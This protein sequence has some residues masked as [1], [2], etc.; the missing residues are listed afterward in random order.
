MKTH[1]PPLPLGY[2]ALA[3]GKVANVVTCLEMNERP[4]LR[5]VPELSQGIDLLPLARPDVDAY[6]ALFR[7]VGCD[8]LWSSR[9]VMPDE[10]L[11][12]ILENPQVE[13]YTLRQ[14][15]KPVGLLEL[16]F[17]E[18]GECELAFFGLVK[19]AIGTGAGRYLMDQAVAKAW[20]KPIRRFWVHTCTFDHQ[21]ALG[22]Y[23]RSGFRPYAFA[24]E[25]MDDPRLTGHL[26]RAAAPHIALLE[27]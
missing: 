9:L 19:E 15:G 25:V 24:V 16:D 17:R 20:A 6:R 14:E 21:S 7:S 5:P 13:L 26:P 3:P 11:R 4:P 18:Q 10:E 2:S 22:F 8:W 1:N 27:R 23:Q 12:A